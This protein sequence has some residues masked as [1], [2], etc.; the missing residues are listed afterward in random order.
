MFDAY[1]KI[2]VKDVKKRTHKN[3]VKEY[4]CFMQ[5]IVIYNPS[6]KTNC[7]VAGLFHPLAKQVFHNSFDILESLNSLFLVLSYFAD[8]IKVKETVYLFYWSLTFDPKLCTV[9]YKM[10]RSF[11]YGTA[12]IKQLTTVDRFTKLPI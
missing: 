9:I 3:S 4:M 5:L 11:S 7:H 2:V 8:Y 1:S 6:F 10:L 12:W